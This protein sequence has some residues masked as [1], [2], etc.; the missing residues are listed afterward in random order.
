[1][2]TIA[3]V[4]D[5]INNLSALKRALR[6]ED[7]QILTFDDPMQALKELEFENVDLIISDYR[8]PHMNGVTFLNEFK[9]INPSAIRLILSG[10]ADLD[11]LLGAINSAEVY[12]FITKPWDDN[13]LRLIIKHALE[14]NYLQQENNRLAQIVRNQ[15]KQIKKNLSE[16]RRLEVD[17]PGITNVDWNEDGSIDLVDEDML[18]VD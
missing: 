10:Q 16:L 11:G 2:T 5:E 8:M 13:D 7:W 12:R 18:D 4:D 14:F 9:K 6:K 15:G 17:S 3:L 1:M